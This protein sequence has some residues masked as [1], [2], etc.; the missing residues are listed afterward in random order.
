MTAMLP[1]ALRGREVV[2]GPCNN[3]AGGMKADPA[4]SE[5]WRRGRG[6]KFLHFLYFKKEKKRE[7][8]KGKKKKEKVYCKT[9]CFRVFPESTRYITNKSVNPALNTLKPASGSSAPAHTHTHSLPCSCRDTDRN[10]NVL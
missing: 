10:R 6:E 2:A 7:R 4:S 8:K 1:R 3:P 5:G 9:Q